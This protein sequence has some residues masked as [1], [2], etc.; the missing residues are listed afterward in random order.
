VLLGQGA[1][2]HG[3]G[4]RGREGVRGELIHGGFAG[5]GWDGGGFAR[6]FKLNAFSYWLSRRSSGGHLFRF[7]S[8]F[9][10]TVRR[11]SSLRG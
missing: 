7:R 11:S 4:G 2:G 9:D 10:A 8:D 6:R 3:L 5:C 1:A